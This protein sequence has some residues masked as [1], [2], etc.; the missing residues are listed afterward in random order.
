MEKKEVIL[1][2]YSMGTK[3]YRV[4]FNDKNFIYKSPC[5]KLPF[6]PEFYKKKYIVNLQ[7]YNLEKDNKVFNFYQQLKNIEEVIALK[8]KTV[9][10]LEDKRFVSSIKGTETKPILRTHLKMNKYVTTE[11][12]STDGATLS[13]KDL[14][15]NT[16]GY[17]ELELKEL[18]IYGTDVGLLWVVNK[19]KIKNYDK[20]DIIKKD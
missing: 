4:T 19:A 1:N 15:I 2:I 10:G 5:V 18:W 17:F 16:Y 20:K 13:L 9:K 8:I 12:K 7:L 3:T 11:I 6:G 14:K